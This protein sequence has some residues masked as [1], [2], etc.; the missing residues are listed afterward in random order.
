MGIESGPKLG[1]GGG[2]VGVGRAAGLGDALN[3]L[4]LRAVP[5][6]FL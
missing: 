4:G 6:T 5:L 3:G 1:F 2:Q